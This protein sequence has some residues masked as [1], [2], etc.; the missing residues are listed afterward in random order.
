MMEVRFENMAR[1]MNQKVVTC[2]H[3]RDNQDFIISVLQACS[4]NQS[5]TQLHN[6]HENQTRL[7]FWMLAS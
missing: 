7:L 6:K 1:P 2:D 4:G 3:E 5:G